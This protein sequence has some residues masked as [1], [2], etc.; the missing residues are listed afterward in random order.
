MNF[1][2]QVIDY[3]NNYMI[4]QVNVTRICIEELEVDLDKVSAYLTPRRIRRYTN[5]PKKLKKFKSLLATIQAK[6]E[7][8]NIYLNNALS[9]KLDIEEVNK[10]LFKKIILQVQEI[11]KCG[12]NTARRLASILYVSIYLIDDYLFQYVN[13]R[14]PLIKE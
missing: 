1:M 10:A 8:E 5:R 11:E 6:I 3:Y 2:I 12:I 14:M 13:L 4:R 9:S 7:E